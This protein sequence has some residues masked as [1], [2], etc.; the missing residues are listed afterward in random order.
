LET[1][2]QKK[3]PVDPNPVE[4]GGNIVIRSDVAVVL[5]KDEATLPDEP[6]YRSH[7]VTCK[8]AAA[9]RKKVAAEKKE[10]EKKAKQPPSL[11]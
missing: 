8:V 4:W 7:F 1:A 3:I 5:K 11:F 2:N 9:N 10:A 6:R